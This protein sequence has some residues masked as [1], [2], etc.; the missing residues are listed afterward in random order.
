[1]SNRDIILKHLEL[2]RA[3]LIKEYDARNFR[4][5]GKFER[6]LEAQATDFGG[7]LLSAPHVQ[8]MNSGRGP[9]SG[10]AATSG[11]L[12]LR[13]AIYQWT[14]DKGI[15][16]ERGMKRE[17]LA[18][19]IARKIHREGYSVKGREGIVEDVIT[20]EKI[21]ALLSELA[22]FNGDEVF[23]EIRALFKDVNAA[24]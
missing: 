22:E 9:T 17:S 11:G 23:R 21:D 7:V 12:S 16:P 18:Y 15:N 20:T 6:D 13:D 1:M 5:S 24:A 14:K 10:S 4:A 2:W 3:E 8:Q 19:L